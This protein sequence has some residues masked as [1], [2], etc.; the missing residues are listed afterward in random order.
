MVGPAYVIISFTPLEDLSSGGVIGSANKENH[1]R[2]DSL[3]RTMER[4]SDRGV[5]TF[6]PTVEKSGGGRD[7]TV[8]HVDEDDSITVVAQLVPEFTKLI[9]KEWKRLKGE[10]LE[11]Y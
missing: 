4:L 9:V 1:I 2:H 11:Q 7:V 6:T 3:K 8:Y 10:N 5:I